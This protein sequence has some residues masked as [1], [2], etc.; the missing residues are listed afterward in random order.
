[1]NTVGN[2]ITHVSGQL[3]DQQRGREFARWS[4]QT[5]MDYYNQARAEIFA[6]RPE[7]FARTVTAPLVPGATQ[8]APAGAA[9]VV[10]V[11]ANSD[12]SPVSVANSGLL[13]AFAPYA[14]C[15][16]ALPYANGT[17][18]YRVLS[19]AVDD[20]DPKSYYVSPAVPV[21]I[22]ATVKLDIIGEATPLTLANWNDAIDIDTKFLNNLI[23]FM[24]ARAYQ[25]NTESAV[26]Q[27]EAQRLYQLFY[28]VMGVK[29]KID[30][31]FKSGYYGGNVG[32]GDPRAMR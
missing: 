17:P 5:L 23:D 15:P 29:Y 11:A 25:L 31:S 4:R 9:S 1:M 2:I 21:G 27:T 28:Q 16:P 3:S 7:A 6:Y 8:T 18:R 19:A 20:K 30:A 24:R 22:D 12:G 10:R 32:D 26:S 13:V 14:A